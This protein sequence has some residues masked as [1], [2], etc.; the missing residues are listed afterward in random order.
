MLKSYDWHDGSGDLYVNPRGVTRHAFPH[1]RLKS[2]K[3]QD[4]PSVAHH[5][6]SR[7]AS[8]TFNQYG[9]GFPNGG[10]NERG[11]AMEVLWLKETQHPKADQ[12]PYV[13]ELEWVQHALDTCSTVEEVAELIKSIRVSPIHG[14]VHYMFCDR[15]GACGVLEYLKGKEQLYVDQRS[16]PALTNHSYQESVSFADQVSGPVKGSG[17]LS[18]FVRAS[19]FGK[20][21]SITSLDQGLKALNRVKIRDYTKWQIAYDL[22]GGEIAFRTS[23]SP[24]IRRVKGSILNQETTGCSAVLT[25][26]LSHQASGEVQRYFTAPSLTTEKKKLRKRFRAIRLPVQLAN[27]LAEHGARCVETKPQ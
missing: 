14:Q 18:R 23:S 4:E 24:S 8:V 11:L 16:H 9:R 10:M 19:Q 21:H 2:R 26:P 17:S 22:K 7:Y 5:W 20:H 15:S 27:T 6:R 3:G 12:R 13:N 25:Y 1:E